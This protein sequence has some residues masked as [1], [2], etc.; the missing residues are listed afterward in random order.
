[1]T[2]LDSTLKSR[3]ITSQRSSQSYGFSSVWKWELGHKESWVVKNWCFWMV[4]LEKTLESSLDCKEIQPVHPKGDQSLIFIG[5]TDAE[6]ETPIL[7]PPDAKKWLIGRDPDAGKDWREEEKGMKE[8]EMVGC[9][10]QLDRHDFKQAPGLVMDR[11]AWCP[12]VYG[13]AKS[14]TRLRDQT[15]MNWTRLSA[16]QIL[17]S[18]WWEKWVLEN[19]TILDIFQ[20]LREALVP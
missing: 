18:L 13:V 14:Q 7:W 3:D 5:R 15:E 20:Q 6:A 16:Y 9:H 4:V 12:A 19:H 1:M 10:H 8:D 2:N 11:E 17:M